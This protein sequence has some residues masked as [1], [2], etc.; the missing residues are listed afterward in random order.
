MNIPIII[1]KLL[2][3]AQIQS[4]FAVIIDKTTLTEETVDILHQ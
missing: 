4:V 3:T 1:L 2:H